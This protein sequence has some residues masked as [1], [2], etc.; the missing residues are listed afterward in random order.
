MCELFG[1]CSVKDYD[2]TNWLKE[3]FSHSPMHPDGWGL[4]TFYGNAASVEKEPV[5]ANDSS[6]LQNRLSVPVTEPLILAHIRKASVGKLG[7]SNCHP[8]VK[9]D[10]GGR[11]WTLIHNGTVFQSEVLEKYPEIQRGSTDSERILLY[12]VDNIDRLEAHLGRPTEAKE[13]FDV[14][15]SAVADVA[16]GNKMNLIIYDSE[17]FYIHVN[18][19]SALH[20]LQMSDAVVVSTQP[21]SDDP[22]QEVPLS[23]VIAFRD[24]HEI[25]RGEDRQHAYTDPVPEDDMQSGM[26]ALF[27]GFGI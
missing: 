6:Y 27:D 12:I 24:G 3:F 7:F 8:F 20:Y 23:T 19:K 25:F 15:E 10:A 21:L 2:V 1:F 17:Q 11:C 14:V 18:M 22:W 26:T 5:C 16:P 9:R 13:R 4:A